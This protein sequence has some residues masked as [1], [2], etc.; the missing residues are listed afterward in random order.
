VIVRLHIGHEVDIAVE[1]DHQ[2]PLPRVAGRI[3][4]LEHIEKLSGF[5][6]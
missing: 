6:G 2:D 1:P 4:V 5:Q 3:G